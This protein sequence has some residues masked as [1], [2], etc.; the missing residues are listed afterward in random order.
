[1]MGWVMKSRTMLV[2]SAAILAGV[3]ACSSA[4]EGNPA[5]SDEPTNG[6]GTT[7]SPAKP[8]TEEPQQDADAKITGCKQT[9]SAVQITATVKNTS[10]ATRSYVIAAVVKGDGKDVG[11]APLLANSVKAGA[12]A[13]ATATVPT[14]AKQVTCEISRV[15]SVAG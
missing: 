14:T 9:G 10:D 6:S 11:G 5:G 8:A 15:D 4:D 1:M 2:L 12:T 13:T 7:S 3:T